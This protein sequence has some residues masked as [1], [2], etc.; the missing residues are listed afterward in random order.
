MARSTYHHGDLR[1]ALIR[2]GLEAIAD[3]GI[4]ALSVAEAARRAGVSPGAPYRHFPSRTALLMAVAIEAARELTADI[5][6]ALTAAD[7]S[8]RGASSTA[9]VPVRPADG[10]DAVEAL[11][12]TAT[13]Y[14]RFV[15]RRRAGLELIFAR[16]LTGSNDPDLSAAGRELTDLLLP[17][18][19][20]LTA[21]DAKAALDLLE[22]HFAAAHGYAALYLS[23][24]MHRRYDD[25]E[26]YGARAAAVTRVLAKAAMHEAQQDPVLL[27]RADERGPTPDGSGRRSAF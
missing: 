5:R 3:N 16:E 7:A 6:A 21:G 19:L 18:V 1:A 27:P 9:T 25:L 15:A 17:L 10:D 13:A 8:R 24:F 20:T 26:Q 12:A 4:G 23:G 2:A 11:A 14:V 22:Q